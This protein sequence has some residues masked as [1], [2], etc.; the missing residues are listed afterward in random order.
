MNKLYIAKAIY[1]FYKKMSKCEKMQVDRS[2]KSERQAIVRAVQAFGKIASNGNFMQKDDMTTED[3]QMWSNSEIQNQ[4]FDD[5]SDVLEHAHILALHFFSDVLAVETSYDKLL[6]KGAGV[7]GV[8]QIHNHLNPK[9]KAFLAWKQNTNGLISRVAYY[10]EYFSTYEPAKKPK[11]PAGKSFSADLNYITSKTKQLR[12]GLFEH[13]ARIKK[14]LHYDGD[15]QDLLLDDFQRITI[16]PNSLSTIQSGNIDDDDDIARL[17]MNCE[18]EGG[19]PRRSP[20]TKRAASPA[21]KAKKAATKKESKKVATKKPKAAKAEK[22]VK[23]VKATKPTKSTKAKAVE[24]PKK[25][26][27]KQVQVQAKPVKKTKKVMA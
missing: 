11:K 6:L 25:A 2:R 16:N 5:Y 15:V 1:F 7:A 17:F 10:H 20:K 4:K 18:L 9:Q 23:A 3:K 26:A 27:A 19:A 24:K 22:K 13:I 21:R 14:Y 8:E 12:S